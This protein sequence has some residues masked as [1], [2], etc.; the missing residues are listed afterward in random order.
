MFFLPNVT[1][2]TCFFSKF[3]KNEKSL[4]PTVQCTQ[5]SN[6]NPLWL[7]PTRKRAM[8]CQIVKNLIIWKFPFLMLLLTCRRASENKRFF[9]PVRQRR[10][11]S[12]IFWKDKINAFFSGQNQFWQFFGDLNKS[13]F[14]YCSLSKRKVFDNFQQQTINF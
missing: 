9:K 2:P 11:S 7:C 1:T 5:N 13:D 12:L 14:A 8:L 3:H 4:Q 10:M 6:R